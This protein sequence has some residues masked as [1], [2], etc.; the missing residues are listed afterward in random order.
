MNWYPN[1]LNEMLSSQ[2]FLYFESRDQRRQ[3]VKLP[4]IKSPP[5]KPG[6]ASSYENPD[7]GWKAKLQS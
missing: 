4:Q 6:V 7:L 2:K 5:Q 1:I 3:S